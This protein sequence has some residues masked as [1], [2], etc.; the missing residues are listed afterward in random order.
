MIDY[1][2]IFREKI[3]LKDMYVYLGVV[4]INLFCNKIV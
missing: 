4:K 2:R 3:K 1:F